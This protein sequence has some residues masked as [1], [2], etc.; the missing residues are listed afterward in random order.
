[1]L[2]ACTN[3]S[4]KK[5][6]L[7]TLNDPSVLNSD[8]TGV[9]T[10]TLKNVAVQ[11]Q[12]STSGSGTPSLEISLSTDTSAATY[13]P[14][15][16]FCGLGSVNPCVCELKWT[17]VNSSNGS[18]NSYQRTKRLAVFAVES[19]RVKCLMPQTG[20][21]SWDEIANA[22]VITMN[23]VPVLANVT[24][25]SVKSLNYKKGT[26]VGAGGDFLDDTLT[27]FRNIHRY[28]CFTK[29]TTSH[30]II[31]QYV[32]SEPA[33]GTSQTSNVILG[34]RFCSA[35][36]SASGN[37]KCSNP[38]NGY[39]AQSYYRNFY[40]RSDKLGEINSTNNTFDCPK[41][42]ES[43]RYSAGATIP[44]SESNQYWP[45]DT[46]FSLAT[47]YSPDWNV[48]VRAASILLKQ[49]DPNSVQDACVNE[50]QSKRLVEAG[51]VTK[52]MGYAKKPKLDGTCGT[53]KDSNG[54]VRP[55]T[56][57]RR[58]RVVYPPAFKP[59]GEVIQSN[60]NA[61][62]V[63]VADRLVV[64]T[65]GVA[66]GSMIY[67][68]K[69]CN[70]A[71]FDHE[72]VVNRSQ[73]L[74]P[75]FKSGL[76]GDDSL[77]Q[78]MPGYVSTAN[79]KH[80]PLLSGLDLPVNPDGLIFPNMD[81]DG[82]VSNANSYASCSATLPKVEYSFGVP[83]RVRLITTSR[84]RGDKITLGSRDLYLNEIHIQPVDPWVPNYL[85]DTSFQAC[86]P[87]ADPYLEPPL[88]IY[89][90]NSNTMGWCTK[91][92]PTQN[93]Y[94]YHVNKEIKPT[95]APTTPTSNI[96]NYPAFA[97]VAADT[98]HK[99][100]VG[101]LDARNTCTGTNQIPLC[102]MTGYNADA[103]CL[104]FLTPGVGRGKTVPDTCDRTVSFDANQAYL[105]FPLQARDVEID[106]ML[107]ADLTQTAERNYSCQYSVHADPN[108]VNS[109]IPATGCCGLVSGVPVLSGV[110]TGPNGSSGHLEPQANPALPN[111]RF[112]GSPVE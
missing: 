12:S 55:L 104:A 73:P 16:G 48:G 99:I 75:S 82:G 92:Y 58:Y 36:D 25:I 67:G 9:Y 54:R 23:I 96:V 60:P 22:T 52:C 11:A 21:G 76:P 35:S 20:S 106:E 71:W 7:T 18:S 88:H 74:A 111:I 105:G 3:I 56:R 38:R 83:N 49:G 64:D 47:N 110:L 95:T 78:A 26:S 44:P 15:T 80:T 112:C 43:L 103:S 97:L 84:T 66:T 86:A 6:L 31:N 1:M 100:G 19:G 24:G 34:S 81:K 93:P 4:S 107:H 57:L 51:T 10:H 85:E 91:A 33:S 39:S 70:F 5:S 72:G 94:W 30:E 45:L 109:K 14:L 32:T 87:V 46:T 37:S 98:S 29:R 101:L 89:K 17:E 65:N 61:D 53:I 28:S 42:V 77:T 79:Y 8:V 102:K 62:E 2:Q 50:D 69:P 68:P 41:V 27:P 63:Y 59:S 108:K 40:I 13:Q 90:E